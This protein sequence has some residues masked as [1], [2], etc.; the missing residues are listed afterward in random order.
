MEAIY[1]NPD[2]LGNAFSASEKARLCKTWMEE[3]RI[4]NS[5]SVSALVGF[6]VPTYRHV[7]AN[8]HVTAFE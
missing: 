4:N 8:S 7:G 6:T 3:K 5:M 2:I 1:A